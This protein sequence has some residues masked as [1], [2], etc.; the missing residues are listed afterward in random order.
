[1][2]AALDIVRL[3]VLGS[4]SP[5]AEQLALDQQALARAFGSLE[6]EEALAH[7]LSLAPRRASGA[8][9]QVMAA[10]TAARCNA[11]SVGARCE[12]LAAQEHP[13]ARLREQRAAEWAAPA[14][15]PEVAARAPAGVEA[16]ARALVTAQAELAAI[17]VGMARNRDTVGSR[18]GGDTARCADLSGERVPSKAELR[19]RAVALRRRLLAMEASL[20]EAHD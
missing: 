9:A 1:M 2:E 8:R 14:P 7:A 10:L 15:A 20:E 6:A 5:G 16:S 4:L 3:S 19:E 12:A 18:E 17:E 11:L 13:R